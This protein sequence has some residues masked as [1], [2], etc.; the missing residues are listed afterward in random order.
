MQSA[1]TPT[2]S[3][4]LNLASVKATVTRV[5]TLTSSGDDVALQTG[6]AEQTKLVTTIPTTTT[7]SKSIPSVSFARATTSISTIRHV[8][9]S[10]GSAVATASSS[11]R[12]S[13]AKQSTQQVAPTVSTTATGKYSPSHVIIIITVVTTVLSSFILA[14]I[15]IAYFR[16]SKR[17]QADYDDHMICRGPSSDRDS[18]SFKPFEKDG[19]I[20]GGLTQKTTKSGKVFTIRRLFQQSDQ[21]DPVIDEIAKPKRTL[22]SEY[23]LS[24]AQQR[25]SRFTKTF[26]KAIPDALQTRRDLLYSTGDGSSLYSTDAE[27]PFRLGSPIRHSSNYP[28]TNTT[29]S[30]TVPDW[31]TRAGDKSKFSDF[32]TTKSVKSESP[33]FSRPTTKFGLTTPPPVPS[34]STTEWYQTQLSNIEESE[35]Q[36]QQGQQGQEVGKRRRRS[37]GA[38]I[39]KGDGRQTQV[40]KLL[41]RA[42]N[43]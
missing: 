39:E 22:V 7:T 32:F 18:D 31:R 15:A 35:Q 8:S 25:F 2:T 41:K 33:N 37:N 24:L 21:S 30:Y 12:A 28:I 5:V 11:A 27:L 4:T 19:A 10:R 14:G 20:Y 40:Y 26:S 13:T 23:K 6:A 16:R 38:G 34:Q 43:R 42:L 1:S 17:R 3:S 29:N 9:A 36:Q